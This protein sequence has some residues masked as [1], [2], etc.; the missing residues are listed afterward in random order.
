MP[1]TIDID[2]KDAGD[3]AALL[4]YVINNEKDSP[5]NVHTARRIRASLTYERVQRINQELV[6]AFWRI[7]NL[8]TPLVFSDT[9]FLIYAGYLAGISSQTS[10]DEVC[11]K[12]L[13]VN[14]QQGD[15]KLFVTLATELRYQAG[16]MISAFGVE[17]PQEKGI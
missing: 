17:P 10:V 12:I 2:E 4:D 8:D 5:I 11:S 13:A 9:I 1:Y 6:N 15:D 7:R 14:D 3:L 16:L